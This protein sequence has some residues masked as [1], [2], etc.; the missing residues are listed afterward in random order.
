MIRNRKVALVAVT[1][2]LALAFTSSGATA[3][4]ASGEKITFIQGVTGDGFY[5]SMNCGIQTEARKLGVTVDVQGG[6][7]WDATIQVPILS[8]VVASKPAAI[9]MAPNDVTAL[10]KPVEAAIAT[11]IKVVM[12]DTTIGDPSK[13]VA[14][15]SSDNVGGGAAAFNAMKQLNPKGG[16]LLVISTSPGVS[17]VDARIK[18][19]NQAAKKDKKFKV[20]KVQ[21]SNNE[22]TKAAQI[23]TSA[24][25]ANPKLVGIFATNLFS[26]EGAATGIA[27]AKRKG[28]IKIVGFDAGA[29]EV[30]ALK[31]GTVQALVA[32]QP[33]S[34]GVQGLDQA[35]AALRGQPVKKKI[36]TGFSILTASNINTPTGMAAQYLTKC[37]S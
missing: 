14:Q 12:V 31:S 22:P 10:Q 6:N 21:Y 24:I 27:Q 37:A 7:K 18:G 16:I 35:V 3:A 11:G 1:S 15:V 36:G 25:A 9:L 4:Y 33:S 23:T 2:A 29:N 34:I 17:T 28:K 32:Q 19:F 30:K 13:V 26:A 5:I 8:S 20:L